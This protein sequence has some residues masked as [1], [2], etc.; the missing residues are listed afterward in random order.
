[1]LYNGKQLKVITGGLFILYGL[2]HM[3]YSFGLWH[4]EMKVD[5]YLIQT[6]GYI[7]FGL[8]L[9]LVDKRMV[10]GV[11][12]I[13]LFSRG[14]WID[15][16]NVVTNFQ[17]IQ[18]STQNAFYAIPNIIMLGAHFSLAVS[19][20]FDKKERQ[21]LSQIST[22]F[23]LVYTVYILY[24]FGTNKFYVEGQSTIITLAYYAIQ[25]GLLVA[26]AYFNRT[27]YAGKSPASSNI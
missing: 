24:M 25:Y 18:Y 13:V 17:Y 5:I 6:L 26:I 19:F 14:V 8:I 20:F 1:M 10:I 12:A 16:K 23:F 22:I 2:L 3:M 21:K 7:I 11:A 15:V 9:I 27:A 4:S